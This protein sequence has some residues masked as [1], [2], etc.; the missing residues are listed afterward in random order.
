VT[1]SFELPQH[2]TANTRGRNGGVRNGDLRSFAE[3][4]AHVLSL[5]SEVWFEVRVLGADVN[6]TRDLP[7]LILR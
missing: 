6:P 1:E 3:K 7:A 5:S 4:M 2:T